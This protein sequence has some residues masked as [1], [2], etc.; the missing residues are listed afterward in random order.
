MNNSFLDFFKSKD[1]KKYE[2]LITLL[3]TKKYHEFIEIFHKTNGK[4]ELSSTKYINKMMDIFK[5]NIQS[6]NDLLIYAWNEFSYNKELDILYEVIGKNPNLVE[7]LIVSDK[8]FKCIRWEKL[9]IFSLDKGYMPSNEFIKNNFSSLNHEDIINKLLDNGFNPD[10][11]FVIKNIYY[12][13]YSN[14]LLKLIDKGFRPTD[15]F[16]EK[17]ECFTDQEVFL[18]L[19]DLG[20]KPTK[21]FLKKYKL[22][23]NSALVDLIFSKTEMTVDF[24]G[25][26][27]NNPYA[28]RKMIQEYSHLLKNTTNLSTSSFEAIWIE[29]IKNGYNVDFNTMEDGKLKYLIQSNYTLLS[30]LVKLNP[31]YIKYNNICD[32]DEKEQLNVLAISLG[33]IPT[34]EDIKEN[35]ALATSIIMMKTLIIHR[36]EAI[37]YVKIDGHNLREDDFFDLCRL[38]LDCGYI[39]TIK[40]LEINNHFY[41]CF[42]IMNQLIPE[43]PNL[44]NNISSNTKLCDLIEIAI[45]NGFNDYF[46]DSFYKLEPVFKYNLKKYRKIP[47]SF[48]KIDY[49]DN[50]SE[51]LYQMLLEYGYNTEDI[52][53]YF[54]GN[55]ELMK[56]LITNNPQYILHVTYSY[57]GGLSIKEIDELCILAID[58]GYDPRFEDDIFGI[59]PNSAKIMITKYPQYL[60]KVNLFEM[61]GFFQFFPIPEYDELCNLACD[62]GYKINPSY[63]GN[64]YENI[65]KVIKRFYHN[66][67]LMKQCIPLNPTLIEYCSINDKSNYDELC[68]LAISNGYKY[69]SKDDYVLGH[70]GKNMLS[71]YDILATIIPDKP[72]LINKITVTEPDEIEKLL[73]LAKIKIEYQGINSPLLSLV[74][75]L[76]KSKWS[77]YL[78]DADIEN[79]NKLHSL[80]EKNNGVVTTVNSSFIESKDI[81][82]LFTNEQIEILTCYPDLQQ[83]L[84]QAVFNGLKFKVLEVFMKKYQENFEWMLLIEKILQNFKKGEFKNLL[85][86]LEDKSLT[87][88]EYNNLICLLLSDNHL[89]ITTYDDLQN[90]KM[91]KKQYIN[92]LI[93]KNTMASLKT[94]YLEK[95]FGITLDMATNLVK[96]YGE[97]LDGNAYSK[98]SDDGKRE[99]VLLD[100]IRKIISINNQDVLKHYIDN[101]NPNFIVTPDLMVTYELKLKQLFTQEFNKSFKKCL[102][103]DKFISDVDDE[104]SLDIYLAAGRNGDIKFRLMITS[105]GAYTNLNEPDDYY[106]SWNI[107]MIAS[108]GCCCS[109]VG[110]KNLG[111]AEVKYCCFGFTDYEDG[112]LMLSAPYDLC[113]FSDDKNFQVKSMHPCMYLLPDDVLEYTRHTHNETVWERR[114]ISKNKTFKKQP[115]YIVYFVDN[116][117]DRLK[118]PEAMKQWNSVKKASTNFSITVDGVKKPLPIMV[119]EREKVAKS[120]LGIIQEKFENFKKT[121]DATLIKDITVDYESNYAGNREFHL[122]ISNKYFPKHENLSDSIVGQIIDIIGKIYKIEP[123]KAR[124]CIYELEKV[125]LNEKNKYNNTKHGTYHSLPSFNIEEALI[126][127][128]KLKN[129]LKLSNNAILNI[130]SNCADN[131]RQF[132]KIDV[133]NIDAEIESQQ[134]SSNDVLNILKKNDLG[135]LV[136]IYENEINEEHINSKLKVHGSRHIKNVL[137]YSALIGQ[138]VIEDKHDLDLI[139]LSAK[140]YKIGKKIDGYESYV[141]ESIKMVKEKLK[142]KLTQEDIAIISTII[143]FYEYSREWTNVDDSF[144]A[145][146]HRNGISD[147]QI[148]RVR[149][150]AEVL[151]DADALDRTRFINKARLNP[152][153]LKFK[154]AKRLIRFASSMQ[155]TYAIKD[156]EEFHCEDAINTLLN[157]YTPQEILR[158]IRHSVRGMIDEKN[159]IN[160]WADSLVNNYENNNKSIS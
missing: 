111:T 140:Y 85:I 10:P 31:Q 51:E 81:T 67:K 1:R 12:F 154:I 145:I 88:D 78:V 11:N 149:N 91:L 37:K 138:E 144:V 153:L 142:N 157:V 116:F 110:E 130:I 150:M 97:S 46:D 139:L 159:F 6:D 135:S 126:E 61:K 143:E 45:D 58:S 99:F 87:E 68:Q 109:Y 147:E 18:K 34:I 25:I 48:G 129:S 121:F 101:I 79:V 13:R 14:I 20:Y 117:E 49:F 93:E 83:E 43:C 32:K 107:N 131:D 54:K 134:I 66:Y 4:C 152:N 47:N 22:P 100:N 94:A 112:S 24:L 92:N 15:E 30:R 65:S 119:V 70:W 146:A 160:S 156:L 9:I 16:I 33:Y 105:I 63:V 53:K 132:Q 137:L 114:N 27:D 113:S 35:D 38:A 124:E 148:E 64:G 155:E 73:D 21:E 141:N 39:P 72:Y 62:L 84:L 42:E 36:P 40:D 75:K 98:L 2:Y 74:G 104:K 125:V 118:D 136:A 77:K 59:G 103:E 108:H 151:K 23:K 120:Q 28:Q 57:L 69:N 86:E 41:E 106:A 8:A 127:I 19:L 56:K 3:E 89:D 71:S 55:F 5:E 80:S 60:D 122:N 90:I 128:N 17:N 82:K 44:I 102:Q 76:D 29:A 96:T 123:N 115:S 52:I 26:L 158:T 95:T 133:S 7:I 50:Y